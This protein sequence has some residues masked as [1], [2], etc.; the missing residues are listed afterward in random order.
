MATTDRRTGPIVCSSAQ[1]PQVLHERQRPSRTGSVDAHEGLLALFHAAPV[2][3]L[4]KAH[5]LDQQHRLIR[6][7]LLDERFTETVDAV[8]VEFGNALHQPLIDRYLAGD[9]P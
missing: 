4:G 9:F 8:V 5:W 1:L 2:V 6:E 7:L 3:A